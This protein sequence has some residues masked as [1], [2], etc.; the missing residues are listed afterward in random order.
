MLRHSDKNVMAA[1]HPVASHTQSS[2]NV[3]AKEDWDEHGRAD[4][5]GMEWKLF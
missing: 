3:H 4:C 2:K 1:Y 5:K